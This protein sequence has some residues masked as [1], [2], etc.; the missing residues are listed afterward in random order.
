MYAD[1]IER[2]NYYVEDYDFSA[3]DFTLHIQDVR[4]TLTAQI[5]S[6][7]LS[8]TDYPYLSDNNVGKVIPFGYSPISGFIHDVEGLC[9]NGKE[10]SSTISPK[11]IFLEILRISSLSDIIVSVKDSND[12]WQLQTSG[13]SFDSSTGI[14]TVTGARTGSSP[15]DVLPVKAD[16]LGIENTYASDIIKDMNSRFLG[17]NYDS[18][19]YNIAEWEIEEKYL[20]PIAFFLS[21]TK[22]IYEWIKELQSLSSVGF[23]YFN[24]SY[25]LRSIRVDN[26]NRNI[27][28]TVP[29]IHIKDISKVVAVSNREEM[30]NK[31]YIGYNKS[32]INNTAPKVEN[33][34]YFDTS[35]AEYKIISIYDKISGLITE[36]EATNRAKIQSSDYNKIHRVYILDLIGKKYLDIELYDIIEATISLEKLKLIKNDVWESKITAGTLI[37]ERLIANMTIDEVLSSITVITIGDEYFG[38]IRGQVI[39]TEPDYELI[40]NKIQLRQE[41]Y[42]TVWEGIYG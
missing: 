42:S 17:L 12:V 31:I 36:S 29:S 41:E 3:D 22:D 2:A 32:I 7:I 24:N 21:S 23:R 10:V 9:V 39:S 4:K 26:P 37:V 34:D 20:K 35:F 14:V 15:Y 30:Y 8:V 13:V 38:V 28:L 40:V 6:V 18:S 27:S 16:V 5:P 25:D 33:I 1:L 11:F 19:N